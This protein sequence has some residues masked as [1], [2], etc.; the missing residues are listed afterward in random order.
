GGRRG[1]ALRVVDR[2]RLAVEAE[3]GRKRRLEARLAGLALERVEE[4]RLLAANV[5][6]GADERVDVEVD[7]GAADVVAEEAGGVGFLQRR[8][9]ARHR[10]TEELAADVVVG[11]GGI[12]G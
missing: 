12:G 8:L 9:E 10:L 1:E 4:R 11:D 5:G 3:V 2:G 6:A 7:P